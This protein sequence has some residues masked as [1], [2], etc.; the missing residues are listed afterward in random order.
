MLRAFG[1][2]V[3]GVAIWHRRAGLG[4]LS[5]S[6][7]G[8]FVSTCADTI[9]AKTSLIDVH[10]HFVPPFYLTENRDRIVAAGGGGLIPLI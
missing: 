9:V 6:S 5:C 2:R 3:T 8:R 4:A 1:L 10:H 7:V